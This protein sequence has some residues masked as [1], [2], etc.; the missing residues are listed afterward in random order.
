MRR[1]A[2]AFLVLPLLAACASSP[3][4]GPS[5]SARER[6][7]VLLS[8][9]DVYRIEGVEGGKAGGLS[10]VRAL[11][12]EL[13]R[14]H[15]DL[16]MLHGGDLLFPSFA[17][18]MYKGEQMVA[19]LNDLDGDPQA[20]D[21]RM[22]VTFGN[23]E[24]ERPK[25][26]DAGV[27]AARVKESQF[28]WLGG[29]VVFKKGADGQPLVGGGAV[30]QVSRTALIESGGIRIG[31]F[32][33]TIPTTGVE[34]VDDFAGPEATARELTADLRRQGAEVVIALTHLNWG[35]DKDLLETLGDAGP[36]LIIGGHDHEHMEIQVGDRWIL[37]A[38]ADARTATV[39]RLHLGA[40][41]KPR[42]EHELRP[43]SG[44]APR[45][46]PQVQALVDRWQ[47]KH[48][49]AFCEQSKAA[50]KCLEEV[51]GRAQTELEAEETKIRGSETS[52]GDWVTD[53]MVAAFAGCGA[54]AAFINSGTLRLNQDLEAGTQITRRHVEELFA[55]PTP[56]YLLRLDGATLQKV[57]D[58]A[59]RG[60]P[61]SGSWLQISGW[62]YQHDQSSKAARK[63]TLLAP[64]GARPLRPDETVLV[65]TNDYVINPDIGDQD[66]YTMLSRDQI[67]PGCA[68][69]GQDLKEIVVRDLRAAEPQGIAPVDEG[70][71]C[72][73]ETKC[74]AK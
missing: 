17:S 8:I 23:H 35:D 20:D 4:A 31:L 45:P 68:A 13:E 27:L 7:A 12:E 32:G 73:P 25:L 39:V 55:Y 37:K 58:Q 22:F 34:Y 72:Q 10:R 6:T 51:Y 54:Q 41:G 61:G 50:P 47:A 43:L 64:G 40:G 26:A 14:E 42:I 53:R 24:F 19:V 67:V 21:P 46:D 60:W 9:N 56:L 5:S 70:R 38:D 44:D 15:P 66:G 69:T 11:R 71:I 65:V 74:L 62:A 16:V 29:N 52:L 18:R 57:A 59:V 3:Q 2:A 63:I 28:H 36:D 30:S 1:L 48:E 49:Q 33:I